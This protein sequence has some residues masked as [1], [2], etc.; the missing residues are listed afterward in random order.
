LGLTTK[1]Q[2]LAAEGVAFALQPELPFA[3][4]AKP[5]RRR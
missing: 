1:A 5:A 2:L 4:P 3:A